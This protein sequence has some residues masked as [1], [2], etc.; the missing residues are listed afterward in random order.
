[1]DIAGSTCGALLPTGNLIDTI[2]GV[3][4]TC[5]DNG[6]AVVVLRPADLGRTGYE[7]PDELN[8]DA[9]LKAKLEKIRL[10]AGQMMNLGDVAKKVVPKMSLIAA[11]R[12][13]GTRFDFKFR[14]R[15]G[16][17]AQTPASIVYDYYNPEQQVTVKPVRFGVR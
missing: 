8:A 6:M 3:K 10:Q 13:G 11:P 2:D 14:L 4:V 1:M 16:L 5:I 15:Y 17:D 9:P 12:A 7:K